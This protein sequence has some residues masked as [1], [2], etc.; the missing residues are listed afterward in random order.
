M[1]KEL[2]KVMLFSLFFFSCDFTEKTSPKK[3][4]SPSNLQYYVTSNKLTLTW[5]DNSNDEDMFLIERKSDLDYEWVTIWRTS[6]NITNYEM[7]VYQVYPNSHFRIIAANALEKSEPSNEVFVSTY[8]SAYLMIY[9]CPN[10]F[11]GCTSN[12]IVI[13]HNCREL[14]NVTAGEWFNTGF[15]LTTNHNYALQFCG[16]CV[17]NCGGATALSTPR[18]FLTN[19][20]YST[21]YG[22]CKTSC[23]PPEMSEN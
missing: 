13:D 8:S 1:K 4:A 21:I 7:N 14:Y 9:I 3:P 17:S 16:G 11:D 2:F 20:F 15:L 18:A 19:K 12:Y 5:E 23:S 22:Y 10:F 6:N